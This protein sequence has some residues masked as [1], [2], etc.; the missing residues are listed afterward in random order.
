MQI[1]VFD[2]KRALGQAAANDL[3]EILQATVA[4]QG[5]AAIILATGNSQLEFLH[6]L[7]TRTG[8]AWNKIVVFQMDEYLEISEQHPASFRRFH[9]EHLIDL[10]HPRAFYGIEGDAADLDAEMAR[11]TAL[12]AEHLPIAC[13]LGIGEN[14]H[15][16]FNDPPADFKTQKQIHIV[17][18]DEAC[19]RQQV[20][21]GHFPNLDAVPTQAL[22]LTVPALL[23]PKHVMAVVPERRKAEAVKAA[24]EGPVTPDCPASILRTQAHVRMYLDGESASLLSA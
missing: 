7:A 6:A 14:G 15:L 20:G 8:I 13:V 12:L 19:R 10:V 24:L 22:S 11:Y 3:A 9:R 5:K 1:S 4:A 21:E 18:L 17:T 23:K 2:S 16:A